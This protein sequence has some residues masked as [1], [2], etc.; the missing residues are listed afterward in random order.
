MPGVGPDIPMHSLYVVPDGSAGR[1]KEIDSYRPQSTMKNLRKTRS[2]HR[3]R[4]LCLRPLGEGG[5]VCV[6]GE[7]GGCPH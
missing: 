1:G 3:F 7:G 4:N 5:R 6:G 2:N